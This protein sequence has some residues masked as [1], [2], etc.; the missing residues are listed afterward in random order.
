MGM[1]WV[2]KFG[3]SSAPA[4]NALVFSCRR[5]KF[6]WQAATGWE[7]ATSPAEFPGVPL[8]VEREYQAETCQ[9]VTQTLAR[10]H[11]LLRETEYHPLTSWV[12]NR[13]LTR[14]SELSCL[15]RWRRHRDSAPRTR[16][17]AMDPSFER[18][19]KP[20]R[21]CV[22]VVGARY[23]RMVNTVFCSKLALLLIPKLSIQHLTECCGQADRVPPAV[24]TARQ[25][26]QLAKAIA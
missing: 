22:L 14:R 24:G 18:P 7:R 9:S 15:M 25:L 4:G 8:E 16:F 5:K 11:R 21:L 13:F 12:R 17:T 23:A 3:N 19:R 26:Y 6:L 20:S 2:P 1:R 10:Q